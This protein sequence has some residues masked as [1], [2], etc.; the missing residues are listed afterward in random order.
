[1]STNR[2]FL[3]AQVIS[4]EFKKQN[5]RNG[6]GGLHILSSNGNW[7][8]EFGVSFPCTLP[9]LLGNERGC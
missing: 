6:V 8:H 1:M 5:N 3:G 9:T 4:A 7:C 2:N